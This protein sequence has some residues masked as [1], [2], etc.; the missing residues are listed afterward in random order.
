MFSFRFPICSSLNPQNPRVNNH[1]PN[2]KKPAKKTH[3]RGTNL[4]NLHLTGNGAIDRK[5]ALLKY[6]IL[7]SKFLKPY[8]GL[9]RNRLE[10]LHFSH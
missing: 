9:S 2:I 5:K 6:G 10:H 8:S 7:I 3:Q 1:P 4:Q